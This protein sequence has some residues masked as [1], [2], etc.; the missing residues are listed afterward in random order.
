ME[1]T[2]LAEVA[3]V[4][5]DMQAKSIIGEFAVG[6]A[7][8]AVLYSQPITTVDLD[9]F[10]LFDPPQEGLILSLETIYNYC[11]EHG[12]EYDG[13][14]IYIAGWPTQFIESAREPLWNEALARARQIVV[15]GREINVLPPEHLGAMWLQAGRTKD[16]RKI[17][18]F[19]EGSVMDRE[20]LRD[21]LQ[22]FGLMEKWRT[23]QGRLSD[24]YHF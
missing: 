10:F 19:D 24:E 14:F 17:E 8:A 23:I 4:L 21:V 2:K 5:D 20:I 11:R 16:F 9:I 18:E 22:R 7:V 1:T 6:G 13:E 3:D 15:D 12:Y